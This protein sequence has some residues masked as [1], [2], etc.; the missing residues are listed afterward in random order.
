MPTQRDQAA[1]RPSSDGGFLKDETWSF[2]GR[3]MVMDRGTTDTP[4]RR[5]LQDVEVEVESSS[6][7]DAGW[8]RWGRATTNAQ[9]RFKLDVQRMTAQPRFI[10]LRVRFRDDELEISGD[11]KHALAEGEVR[12]NW[13]TVFTSTRKLGPKQLPGGDFVFDGAKEQ[14]RGSDLGDRVSARTALIWYVTRCAQRAIRRRGPWLAFNKRVRV[15]FPCRAFPDSWANGAFN[16]F[17]IRP[18]DQSAARLVDVTLH[19]LM[20]VWNFQHNSGTTNWLAAVCD[21]STHSPREEPNVAFHEGF[22]EYAAQALKAELWGAKRGRPFSRRYLY[23]DEGAGYKATIRTLEELERWDR[24]VTSA[25]WL[26]TAPGP[27]GVYG[28]RLGDRH[29]ASMGAYADDTTVSE[30][31][32]YDIPRRTSLDLWDVMRAFRGRE[33]SRWSKDWQVGRGSYGLLRFLERLSDLNP[34][35][36]HAQHQ[37]LL[38]LLDP[39]SSVEALDTLGRGA[40]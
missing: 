19:E 4:T 9:G 36:T 26:L 16:T 11:M 6:L 17:Y 30:R 25:L 38:E 39:G 22:A 29:G 3:L 13:H 12:H 15:V 1:R 5:P 35:F 28:Y 37:L 7:A 33:D 10:R 32:P 34:D 23:H 20:H 2:D 8:S 40:A 31:R 27:L 14:T 24:G 18:E 21:G